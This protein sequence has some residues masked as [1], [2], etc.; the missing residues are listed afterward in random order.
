MFTSRTKI[1]AIE[2][3]L[4]DPQT[5]ATVLLAICLDAYGTE[6][7]DWDPSV[8]RLELQT[9]Y[10]AQLPR[11][12]SDKLQAAITLMT[13]DT[14]FNDVLSFNHIT[15]ALNN[16]PVDFD[17]LDPVTPDQMAWA[18]VEAR[19]LLEGDNDLEFADEVRRYQGMILDQHGIGKPH[20]IFKDAHT[21]EPD[22]ASLSTDPVMYDSYFTSQRQHSDDINLHIQS[23]LRA[24]F[25][26]LD[27]IPIQKRDDVS[28]NTFQ[29][30]SQ[31]SLG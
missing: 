5:Y 18:I 24:L 8:L 26:Q 27:T 16:D 15:E 9:D 14:F 20:P 22:T 21:P 28:W 2:K 29:E 1:R 31:P 10:R 12:N 23:H 3:V 13:S 19:L 4:E 6:F 17:M 25:R 11:I 7:L 30:R